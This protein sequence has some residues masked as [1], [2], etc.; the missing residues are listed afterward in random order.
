MCQVHSEQQMRDI[1]RRAGLN[2]TTQRLSVYKYL[3]NCKTH[4]TAEEIYSG[5]RAEKQNMSRGTI[6]N[7]LKSFCDVG[8]VRVLEFKDSETRYD[9]DV[10]DHAH[11]KCQK[12]GR[13]IDIDLPAS[14]FQNP[15]LA[16][17][18]IHNQAVLLTGIC[19]DCQEQAELAK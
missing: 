9:T 10:M 1:I 15:A 14:T 17:F 5:I 7:T 6:Y 19:P 8:L 2:A 18:E 11:F 13:L 16:G 4:P 12:C 3:M